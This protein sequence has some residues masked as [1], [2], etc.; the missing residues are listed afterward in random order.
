MTPRKLL[1][2]GFVIAAIFWFVV[3]S[4]HV[5]QEV[6]TQQFPLLERVLQTQNAIV[7][8]TLIVAG[9]AVGATIVVFLFGATR[10]GRIELNVWG[11]KAAGPSGPVLL[12]TVAF[13]AIVTAVAALR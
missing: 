4:L 6:F 11:L 12:W 5:A 1:Q 13:V 8:S 2:W 10:G 3:I 7:L 9:A